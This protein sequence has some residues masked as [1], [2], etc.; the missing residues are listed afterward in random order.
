MYAYLYESSEMFVEINNTDMDVFLVEKWINET[1]DANGGVIS[2]EFAMEI[3][4]KT[5]HFAHIKKVINHIKLKN[6]TVEEISPY[7][8]FILSCVDGRKQEGLSLQSL[9][10]I[11]DDCGFR[12]EFEE[13]NSKQP[14]VYGK[15]DCDAIVVNDIEDFKDNLND[16]KRIIAL[17]CS[18]NSSFSCY[19]EDFNKVERLSVIMNNI[20]DFINI[21][22]L[23]Q[24]LNFAGSDF[25][26]IM[27]SDCSKV[28]E[29]II[30]DDACVK[31]IDCKGFIGS[32]DFSQASELNLA[33][34]DFS[35]A[36]YIK[37]GRTSFADETIMPVVV[38]MTCCDNLETPFNQDFSHTKTCIMKKGASYSIAL[39]S[40][41]KE[42]GVD[43]VY[44]GDE[45]NDNVGFFGRLFSRGRD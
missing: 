37:L 42:K 38:D 2:P 33:D 41:L 12:E 25:V 40:I 28:K 6:K 23:P 17:I 5:N 7:K 16:K 26:N 8:E 45:E 32:Y 24:K 29:I 18:Q 20:I 13:V 35:K 9:Q 36:Q 27:N 3:L 14:K 44:L 39:A 1:R 15:D 21:Q 30:K 4:T 10:K 19:N 11:A 43:V 22:N 31:F 34:S